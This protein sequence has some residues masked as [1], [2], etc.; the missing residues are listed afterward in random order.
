MADIKFVCGS[1]GQHLQI[2]EDCQGLEIQCPACGV[3]IR[4]PGKNAPPGPDGLPIGPKILPRASVKVSGAEVSSVP[5]QPAEEPAPASQS[6]PPPPPETQARKSAPSRSIL[7]V[8]AAIVVL[9]TAGGGVWWYLHQTETAGL[10][11]GASGTLPSTP[12]PTKPKITPAPSNEVPP[13]P[14]QPAEFQFPETDDPY[15]Y[16][17][18]GADGFLVCRVA[19]IWKAPVTRAL[20]SLGNTT[21]EKVEKQ[22]QQELGIT[23]SQIR[24]VV[25]GLQGLA[26][27]EETLGAV[28]EMLAAMGPQAK[29][30]LQQKLA[31]IDA[32]LL[33]FIETDATNI[34]LALKKLGENVQLYL[35]NTIS[36]VF[37]H[38]FQES[39]YSEGLA[40]CSIQSGKLL[41]GKQSLIKK[42]LSGKL[43]LGAKP[44]PCMNLITNAQIL[45]AGVYVPQT[46]KATNELQRLITEQV[47]QV[48]FGIEI[49]NTLA[50]TEVFVCRDPQKAEKIRTLMA[51][52]IQKSISTLIMLQQALPP[53]LHQAILG[54]FK[55]LRLWNQD[56]YIFMQTQV[57]P[58][59]FQP[60]T[61]QS[62]VQWYQRILQQ[63]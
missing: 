7:F 17:P 38:T 50:F 15:A 3:H 44:L 10:E 26:E 29:D 57:P 60:A 18:R 6:T 20:F 8:A 41:V 39:L 48:A 23:P 63:R 56:R 14:T 43:P 33:G 22:I 59:L 12:P 62:I 45:F 30:L 28:G 55:N 49:T 51:A 24:S 11:L 25:F 32:P 47:Q 37:V 52:D 9:L 13:Q 19:E 42:L 1:C 16:L 34:N 53:Q 27:I 4:V 36:G 21:P 31:N 54:T 58:T 61:L 2:E 5:S 40:V 35:T 46:K